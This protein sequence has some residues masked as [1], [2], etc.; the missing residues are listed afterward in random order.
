MTMR[1][2]RTM[3]MSFVSTNNRSVALPDCTR[4]A[5]GGRGH[6]GS[7]ISLMEI[8]R[9]LEDDILDQRPDEPR[10][11]ERDRCVLSKGPAALALYAV[12]ATR[13]IFKSLP[14]QLDPWRTS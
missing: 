10:W 2:P 9:V 14:P 1:N 13:A 12:L 11:P 7:S 3:G 5:G 8:L 6:I 4:A